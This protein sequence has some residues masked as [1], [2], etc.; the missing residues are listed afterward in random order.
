MTP[1]LYE[2]IYLTLLRRKP[3]SLGGGKIYPYRA[4]TLERREGIPSV[5][6]PSKEARERKCERRR[7]KST[8]KKQS[9]DPQ[10]MT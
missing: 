2:P 8:V 4:Q 7:K 3:S 9:E 1:A 6:A 5:H 10:Y